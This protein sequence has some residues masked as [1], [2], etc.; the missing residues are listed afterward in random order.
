MSCAAAS[1][2]LLAELL[3]S[4]RKSTQPNTRPNYGLLSYTLCRTT[5]QHTYLPFVV[6]EKLSE[7]LVSSETRKETRLTGILKTSNGLYAGNDVTY[8]GIGSFAR[9]FHIGFD[10]D[11]E[12]H[13]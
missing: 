13:F 2:R 12:S 11:Y 10:P 1:C 7:V 8:V 9:K 3:R 5:I 6:P 4:T